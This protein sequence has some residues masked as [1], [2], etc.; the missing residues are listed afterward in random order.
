MAEPVP[1]HITALVQGYNNAPRYSIEHA[2]RR[3]VNAQYIAAAL[4]AL[5]A[6]PATYDPEVLA[7]AFL[8]SHTFRTRLA[9]SVGLHK[10]SP[11]CFATALAIL[12]T[13]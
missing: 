2:Y 8:S 1:A 10:I 7:A 6:A 12:E 9:R 5:P 4:R 3:A 11:E 13:A